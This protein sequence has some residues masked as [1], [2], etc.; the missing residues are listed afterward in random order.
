M[1]EQ[2]FATPRPI[3]LELKIA[4]GAI[5]VATTDDGESTVSVTGSEKLVGATS[6]EL[7]G[8]RLVVEN[9]RRLFSGFFERFDGPLRVQARVPNGSRV[10]IATAAADAMLDGTFAGLDARSA[11]GDL[12]AAGAVEGDAVVKNVSGEVRLSYV[13]GDLTVKTVS[14]DV[15]A[16]S[17]GGSVSV[18]SV[19]GDVRV[20]SLRKGT[21]DIQS[22][23]GDIELGVAPGTNL[24]VDAGSASGELSSEVPLSDTPSGAPG[25][26]LVV[27]GRTVSGDVRV[28][29]SSELALV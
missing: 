8:D 15:V 21:V 23:S 5:E 2:R 4:V 27:R 12:R 19:S 6:V 26:T 11:S 9:Q 16:G 1:A 17:V 13:S 29:R 18:K 25:P 22:V 10:E 3:R 24:D 20:G 28:F 7:V 14:G